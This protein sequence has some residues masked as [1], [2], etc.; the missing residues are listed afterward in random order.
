MLQARETYNP[1][2]F[3]FRT[4]SIVLFNDTFFVNKFL[5]PTKNFLLTFRAGVV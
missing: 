5:C 2:F 4:E 3:L 1:Q